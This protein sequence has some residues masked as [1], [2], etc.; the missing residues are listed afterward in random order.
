MGQNTLPGFP[1]TIPAPYDQIFGV[2]IADLDDDSFPDVYARVSNDL[3]TG[4]VGSHQN[5]I[6]TIDRNAQMLPG[7]NPLP[8][9]NYH[10]AQLFVHL[11]VENLLHLEN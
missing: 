5:A 11:I 7:Y 4:L 1:M 9:Q 8:L 10:Q 3:R 6:I 2:G